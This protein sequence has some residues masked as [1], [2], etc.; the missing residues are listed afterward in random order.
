MS[1]RGGTWKSISWLVNA[2]PLQQATVR[3]RIVI[4]NDPDT[5]GENSVPDLDYI[6][7][8]L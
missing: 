3:A 6:E 4:M 2:K 7:V 8:F 1:E 5:T